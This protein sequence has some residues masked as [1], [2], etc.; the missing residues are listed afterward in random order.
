MVLLRKKE[1]EALES[2]VVFRDKIK[3]GSR[4]TN[5]TEKEALVT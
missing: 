4:N 5:T 3:G 1:E 2:Q